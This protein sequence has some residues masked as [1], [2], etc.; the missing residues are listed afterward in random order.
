MISSK[1]GITNLIISPVKSADMR[2]PWPAEDAD[3]EDS[4]QRPGRMT[5]SLSYVHTQNNQFAFGH[6]A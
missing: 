5:Q 4:L 2:L 3:L 6:P 1:T